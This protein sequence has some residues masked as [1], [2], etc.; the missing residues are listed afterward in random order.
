MVNSKVAIF[1]VLA[2]VL[3]S[4][5]ASSIE[6]LGT[7][8]KGEDVV[9]RQVCSTC[10][11]VNITSVNYPNSTQIIGPVQMNQNGNEFT[12]TLDSNYTSLL[13][14]YNVEGVLNPNGNQEEFG[15]T[16]EVTNAG[17][18]FSTGEAL[19]AVGAMFAAL[20]TSFMF[21]RIGFNLGENQRYIPVSFLFIILSIVL[22]TYGLFLGFS[23]GQ[24][25]VQYAA[26]SSLA[27]TMFFI[28]MWTLVG[29]AILFMALMLIAFVNQLNE[30][31]K[32]KKFGDDF[33]PVTNTYE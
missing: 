32:K 12:Y 28:V 7:F 22:T 9:L 19:G 10:T 31:V 25:I 8:E 17:K 18:N 2:L 5:M 11:S 30:V 21:S 6:Q 13:G 20:F 27:E 3:M 23:F 16:F 4:P 24:D 33:N 14:T 1:I 29:I 15:Y 26:L